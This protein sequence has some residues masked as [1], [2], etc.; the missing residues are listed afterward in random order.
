M[1]VSM[2]M[3]MV[4]SRPNVSGSSSVMPASG[5][6][7][8]R[9]PTTVPHRQPMKQYRRP[10]QDKA[11]EKPRTSCSK[12]VIEEPSE[13]PD[14]EPDAE[15]LAEQIPARCHADSRRYYGE[16]Q[17]DAGDEHQQHSTHE[18]ERDVGAN[19]LKQ[20]R[21]RQQ[22]REGDQHLNVA[23]LERLVPGG[24]TPALDRDR[25]REHD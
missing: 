22:G 14:R 11:T 24:G 10:F 2:M 5:P 8:G 4:G 18:A 16:Q 1:P 7:P 21:N 3:P 20:N 9:T 15:Q 25:H 19:E 6:S 17:R 23:E 13:R 12:P